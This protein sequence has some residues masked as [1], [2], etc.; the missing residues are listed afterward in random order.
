[1]SGFIIKIIV[2]QVVNE[3]RKIICKEIDQAFRP[4]LKEQYMQ[5]VRDVFKENAE[6]RETVISYLSEMKPKIIIG[7]KNE[8]E[9]PQTGGTIKGEGEKIPGNYGESII[10]KTDDETALGGANGL[11]NN[12]NNAIDVSGNTLKG[13]FDANSAIGVTDTL[14]GKNDAKD[15]VG[16]LGDIAGLLSVLLQTA[17]NSDAFKTVFKIFEDE[18]K[19][20]LN[21][22][23]FQDSIEQGFRST[24]ENIEREEKKEH[25]LQNVFKEEFES[26]IKKI[27]NE[28][29]DELEKLLKDQI[30]EKKKELKN[31]PGKKLNCEVV[32]FI[33]EKK[34]EKKSVSAAPPAAVLAA[35]NTNAVQH[36]SDKNVEQSDK[37]VEQTVATKKKGG[38]R[39]TRKNYK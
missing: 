20:Y 33:S 14:K 39:R 23:M 25:F 16:Q 12:I 21:V 27:L 26:K 31:L 2:D 7:I 37:N 19:K 24:F 1:M 15:A 9:H 18:L 35:T 4:E 13:F 8:A 36:Q 29:H 11:P 3:V 5:K 30:E 17:L 38:R 10:V 22:P 34:D 6:L 32:D 28:K